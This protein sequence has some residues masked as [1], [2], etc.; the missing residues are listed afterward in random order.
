M[1]KQRFESCRIWPRR[2][3]GAKKLLHLPGGE[4]EVRAI[5]KLARC[6]L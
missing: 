1:I 4:R 2:I 5:G 3:E 6:S